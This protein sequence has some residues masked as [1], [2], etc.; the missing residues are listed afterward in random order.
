MTG[1]VWFKLQSL[2]QHPVSPKFPGVE[3][4]LDSDFI[5]T[6]DK[7]KIPLA[8]IKTSLSLDPTVD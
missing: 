3:K 8:S 2:L 1:V 6:M 4:I 5:T 7:N